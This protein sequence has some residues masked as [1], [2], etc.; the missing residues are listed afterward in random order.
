MKCP[1]PP[2][3]IALLTGAMAGRGIGN[4]CPRMQNFDSKQEMRV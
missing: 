3:V 1:M 4:I 2:L